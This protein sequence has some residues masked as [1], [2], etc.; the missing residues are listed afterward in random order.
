MHRIVQ[1]T[2]QFLLFVFVSILLEIINKKIN[3]NIY[4]MLQDHPTKEIA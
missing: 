2:E 3:N 4:I 1:S